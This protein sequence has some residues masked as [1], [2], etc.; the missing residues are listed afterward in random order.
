MNINFGIVVE[1]LVKLDIWF[2][3]VEF[4]I[5]KILNVLGVLIIRKNFFVNMGNW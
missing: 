5:V 3:M 4:Y 2:K 1:K